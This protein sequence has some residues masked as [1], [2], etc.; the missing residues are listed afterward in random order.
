MPTPS[1]TPIPWKRGIRP[2]DGTVYVAKDGVALA[3]IFGAPELAQADADFIARACNAHYD[4]LA[5]LAACVVALQLES[6][7]AL[8]PYEDAYGP[9]RATARAA[10][11]RAKGEA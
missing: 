7:R 6:T 3:D 2:D 8:A 5:A 4:L 1:H 9:L 10:I 11:Q